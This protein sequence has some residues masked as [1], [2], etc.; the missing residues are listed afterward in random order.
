[1]RGSKIKLDCIKY[2][3]SYVLL[4]DDINFKLRLINFVYFFRQLVDFDMFTWSLD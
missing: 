4:I 2:K 3:N 1:M